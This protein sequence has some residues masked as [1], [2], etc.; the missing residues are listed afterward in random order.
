MNP[1]ADAAIAE[2]RACTTAEQIERTAAKYRAQVMAMKDSD[3]A[4]YHHVL[5]AK[6]WYMKGLKQ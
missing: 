3:P 4:R 1:T 5:N 6:R 2:F